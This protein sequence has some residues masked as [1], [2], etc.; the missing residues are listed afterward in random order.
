MYELKH[1][2]VKQVSGGRYFYV[3]EQWKQDN[4]MTSSTVLGVW[5][6]AMGGISSGFGLGV[7]PGLIIGGAAGSA[8]GWAMAEFENYF[9]ENDTWYQNFDDFPIIIFI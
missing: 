8:L 4:I 5:G 9:Y 7:L 3:D 6:V 2:Q 1:Q